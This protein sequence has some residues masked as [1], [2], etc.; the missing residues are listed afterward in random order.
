MIG[1]VVSCG[2]VD[3]CSASLNP[4]VVVVGLWSKDWGALS[5]L[6]VE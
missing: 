6:R 2:Q 4:G 1:S 5:T 3:A